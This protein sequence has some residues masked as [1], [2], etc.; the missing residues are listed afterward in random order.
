MSLKLTVWLLLGLLSV[1][2]IYYVEDEHQ[3]FE[4]KIEKILTD[5]DCKVNYSTKVDKIMHKVIILSIVQCTAM[6]R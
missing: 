3:D 4:E 5:V 2:S 1:E 6:Q